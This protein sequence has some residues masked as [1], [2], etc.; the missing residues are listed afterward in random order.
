M[1]NKHTN[2]TIPFI[3]ASIVFALQISCGPDPGQVAVETDD[4]IAGTKAIERV[5]DQEV[6][7]RIALMSKPMCILIPAIEK[8]SDQALLARIAMQLRYDADNNFVVDIIDR[9]SDQALLA[10][11]VNNRGSNGNAS[12]LALEKI[13]DPLL[14][15]K[16]AIEGAAPKAV[17]KINDYPTLKRV[18]LECKT[19]LVYEFVAEKLIEQPYIDELAIDKNPELHSLY[20]L[21]SGLKE[22]PPD[23]QPGQMEGILPAIKFL[24]SRD[25]IEAFGEIV[26]IKGQWASESREYRENPDGSGKRYFLSRDSLK[27][28][29]QLKNMKRPL[30]GS[31]SSRENF[32][33]SLPYLVNVGR[34]RGSPFLD[35]GELIRP[36]LDE[37]DDQYLLGK[38]ALQVYSSSIAFEAVKRISR[39]I[40]LIKLGRE[41][42][43]ADPRELA[44]SKLAFYKLRNLEQERRDNWPFNHL[45]IWPD[46]LGDLVF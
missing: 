9:I 41:T 3:M 5:E 32:P 23:Q 29:V 45:V 36:V 34:K 31:W 22:I 1:N 20:L 15:E 8:I 24:N 26:S 37:I 12:Y 27:C 14:I 2:G 10:E 46:S 11:I 4:C 30:T 43:F 16:I 7:A 21:K 18:F 44:L 28:S 40:I 42:P 19:P 35:P 13:A 17:D 38:Y 39:Q 6:L 25:V 33:L